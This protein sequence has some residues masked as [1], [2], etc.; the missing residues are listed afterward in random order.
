MIVLRLIVGEERGLACGIGNIG[1]GRHE[2]LSG[3]AHTGAKRP[4][5]STVVDI[6]AAVRRVV[7]IKR[8]AEQTFFAPKID[9]V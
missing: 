6:K 3:V 1:I 2:E 7:R 9:L 8:Q 5:R 4:T